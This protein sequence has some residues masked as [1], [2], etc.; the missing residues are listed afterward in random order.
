MLAASGC[1]SSGTPRSASGCHRVRAPFRHRARHRFERR[2]A[3][4]HAEPDQRAEHGQQREEWNQRAQCRLRGDRLALVFGLRDLQ[5]VRA[6]HQ[7]VARGQS[8]PFW[9]TVE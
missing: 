2:E 6:L 9:R 5:R 1:N 4:A 8:R 3:A 7:R